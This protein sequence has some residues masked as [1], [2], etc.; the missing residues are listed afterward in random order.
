MLSEALVIRRF[1]DDGRNMTRLCE[2]DAT[3]RD[4]RRQVR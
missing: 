2:E 3:P 1:I 4:E